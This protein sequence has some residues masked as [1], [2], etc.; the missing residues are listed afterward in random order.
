MSSTTKIAADGTAQAPS[1]I[2]DPMHRPGTARAPSPIE[3]PMHQ[4]GTAQAHWC[5]DNVGEAAP[6]VLTPLGASVWAIV[7]DSAPREVAYR[8]GVFSSAECA[9]AA[10]AS[11]RVATVFFGRFAMKVEYMATVGDRMPGTTGEDTVKGLFG[12]VPDSIS[13]APTRRRYPFIAAKLPGAFVNSPRRI[14]AVAA[15]TDAWWRAQVPALDD[16]DRAQAIALFEQALRRF[17]VSMVSHTV[18]LLG[19]VQPLYDALQKLT[20]RAGVGDVG[21][22]SGSGGAEMAIVA[23]IWRASRGL[24]EL[25]EVVRNQGF[26]GPAEGE[27]SSRVWREDPSPLR[28]LIAEYRVKPDAAD[29][30]AREEQLRRR[31]PELQRQ[32]LDALPAAQRPLAGAVLTLAAR[33]IPLRGVGKRSF[34]QSIDVAR[35][36][37]RA[38]GRQMAAAG[39]LDDPEDV[40]YLTV[41]ELTGAT[42]VAVKAVVA[43]RKDLR[44]AYQAIEIPGS[45]KGTPEPEAPQTSP[46]AARTLVE[47]KGVSAG[48]V[49]GRARV[50]TDP[51]F[52]EVEPGEVLVAP[53]TDPSWAS[54]MFVSAALVV[55]IGGP[56]SHAA[57]VARELSLPCVVNTRTGTRDLRTGDLVR[58]DGQ[59]GTVQVLKRAPLPEV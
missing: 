25:D 13:F 58:V 11:E 46:A 20:E 24:I 30:R 39:E 9:P 2:G 47:G 37:A 14:R 12:H 4:P 52:A 28:R 23:D 53:T 21:A 36:A 17:H 57:V 3:D 1:P 59:A 40:F 18:G 33:L 44:A 10:S 45:W 19:T 56:L 38:V 50:F 48:V 7:G 34:L 22:L 32:V 31:L 27:L 8:I 5:T 41:E 55:D 16:L 54:V 29:P 49:E 43:A 35:G 15:S 26:H 6:G 51:S 42:A